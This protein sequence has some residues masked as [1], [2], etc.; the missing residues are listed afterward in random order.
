MVKL[1]CQLAMSLIS[2][3]TIAYI[4]QEAQDVCHV[5]FRYLLRKIKTG[6]SRKKGRT[7]QYTLATDDTTA[8]DMLTSKRDVS[9]LIPPPSDG[10]WL[11][12]RSRVVDRCLQH[13]RDKGVMGD[14]NKFRDT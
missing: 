12:G 6:D 13:I 4:D 11:L 8:T 1:F 3:L 10:Y 9:R 5:Q 7:E 14:G 2:R